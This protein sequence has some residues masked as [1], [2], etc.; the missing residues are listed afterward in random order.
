MQVENPPDLVAAIASD[1]T[2]EA[3]RRIEFKIINRSDRT[4]AS[5]TVRGEAVEGANVLESHEVILDYVPAHSAARGA[6]IFSK[7]LSGKQVRI[8]PTAYAEP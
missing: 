1:S 4:A 8:R 7:N 2:T 6:F 5:V 3:G